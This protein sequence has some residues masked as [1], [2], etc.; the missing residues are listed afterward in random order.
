MFLI[1][2][3][4]IYFLLYKLNEAKLIP[5]GD[6]QSSPK[7]VLTNNLK[8]DGVAHDSPFSATDVVPHPADVVTLLLVGDILEVETSHVGHDQRQLQVGDLL[9]PLVARSGTCLCLAVEGRL[10]KE[11]RRCQL[12]G[13]DRPN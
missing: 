1:S 7:R 6:K 10:A 3:L 11:V 12:I 4:K 2:K 9:E 13:S 5:S 8:R